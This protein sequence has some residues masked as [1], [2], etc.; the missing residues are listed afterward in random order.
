MAYGTHA[1]LAQFEHGLAVIMLARRLQWPLV[2]ASLILCI[3]LIALVIS[4]KRRAWWL[5]GLAP[6][7][8]LFVHRFTAGPAAPFAVY[9]EPLFVTVAEA[10]FLG[11]DDYVVGVHFEDEAYAY[12]FGTLFHHPLV[13]QADHDK[14]MLLMWSPLANRAM[15]V[16]IARDVHGRDLDIVSMPAGALLFYNR[17]IGQFINGLTA[18]T[19]DG[20]QPDGFQASIPATKSTWKAWR[21]AN[22]DTH[23]LAAPGGGIGAGPRL[24]IVSR[25]KMPRIESDVPP[26]Q[27]IALVAT[28][29]PA[30]IVPAEMNANPLN[31]NAGDTPV[32]V[33]RDPAG[34]LRAFDRH[35]D[36]DLMPPFRTARGEGRKGAAFIDN[37]TET[38]WSV[39][40]VAM[41]GD[42]KGKKLARVAVEEDLTWGV[43]KYWY[44][45]LELHHPATQPSPHVQ[46]NVTPSPEPQRKP[47]TS[48][49]HRKPAR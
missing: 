11:D 10:N 39:D 25:Q 18:R 41:D 35:V 7:L 22:P 27:P 19:S 17:R 9:D 44:P 26:D 30:A 4:G 45:R 2:A 1:D 23:V 14:R 46:P 3:A 48:R 24:P 37:Y 28:T 16:G 33:F 40:G 13:T 5:I 42:M 38:A 32:F 6:V 29:Q 15:A 31:L 47:P 21:A 34:A 36:I 12:P 43:M 49:P 20:M 8:A